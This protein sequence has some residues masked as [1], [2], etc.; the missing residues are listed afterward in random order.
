MQR[1]HQHPQQQPQQRP[2]QQVQ[3]KQV[4]SNQ[5]PSVPNNITATTYTIAG[6]IGI[7]PRVEVTFKDFKVPCLLD[8]G[9]T[10]SLMS[11]EVL[12][13]LEN[14]QTTPGSHVIRVANDQIMTS[15]L[16][17]C[18]DIRIGSTL[19]KDQSF[20]ICPIRQQMILG[21]NNMSTIKLYLN[22]GKAEIDGH[23]VDLIEYGRKTVC[24][25]SEEVELEPGMVNMI[26]VSNPISADDARKEP[27]IIL[28]N[29]AEG[30]C[31]KEEIEIIEG[32]YTNGEY[33][34]V[35]VYNKWPFKVVIP[36]NSPIAIGSTMVQTANGLECN[37]LMEVTDDRNHLMEYEKHKELRKRK[38]CPEKSDAYKAVE[39]GDQLSK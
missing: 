36:A 29:P 22:E 8:S 35:P 21:T 24:T 20:I 32:A 34:I 18:L 25:V 16:T 15:K 2:Q 26:H 28:E 7:L 4:Q 37:S 23:T 38:F 12:E 5:Q 27:V 13:R 3:S 1:P 19:I 31:A 30:F 33:I 6:D 11:P 17:V 9:S 39:I 10:V 14:V